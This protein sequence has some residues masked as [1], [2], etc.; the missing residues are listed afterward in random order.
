[1][2]HGMFRERPPYQGDTGGLQLRFGCTDQQGLV[3]LIRK[4]AVREG[5]GR[6]VALGCAEAS[7]IV[8][9]GSERFCL[10]VKGLEL[11]GIAQRSMLMVAL[12]IAVSESGPDHTRWYP[13]Y[14]CHP[15]L[16]SSEELS[17][18]AACRTFTVTH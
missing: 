12:G 13:P 18:P 8:G 2:G 15:N 11:E 1:M 16:L 10:T 5:F 6:L 4:I 7:K 9:K 3:E 17:R 14:P